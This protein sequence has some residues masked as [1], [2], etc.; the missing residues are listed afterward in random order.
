MSTGALC[1]RLGITAHQV[2][3][4]ILSRKLPEPARDETGRFVWPE[5]AVETVRQAVAIDL[6]R[7]TTVRDSRTG[8]PSPV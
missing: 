8:H 5:S 6:R 7:K 4:A 2:R 3:N 1:R